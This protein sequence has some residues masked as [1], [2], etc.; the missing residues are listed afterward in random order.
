MAKKKTEPESSPTPDQPQ[1][2]A[3]SEGKRDAPAPV[4]LVLTAVP[5]SPAAAEAREALLKAIAREADSIAKAKDKTQSAAALESLARAYTL[6][7]TAAPTQ[8][9]LHAGGPSALQARG[10]KATLV[11]DGSPEAEYTMFTNGVPNPAN[12]IPSGGIWKSAA[13]DDDAEFTL[14]ARTLGPGNTPV[15]R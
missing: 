8:P 5:Q 10:Q 1:D 13:L 9:G 11:W 7:T 3:S 4:G 2:T 6:V 15:Y 14:E 12:N